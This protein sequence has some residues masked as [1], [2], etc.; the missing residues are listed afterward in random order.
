M[1]EDGIWG[2]ERERTFLELR[3]EL[4]HKF[5][6]W[7]LILD[8]LYIYLLSLKI[9]QKTNRVAYPKGE[10]ENISQE[11]FLANGNGIKV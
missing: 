7:K 2:R 5:K 4:N 6:D 11:V 9:I 3:N 1:E 10:G 8:T